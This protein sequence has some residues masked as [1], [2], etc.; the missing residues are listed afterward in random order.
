MGPLPGG[1][2]SR[3]GGGEGC[4]KAVRQTFVRALKCRPKRG[5]L[6]YPCRS[7]PLYSCRI[8]TSPGQRSVH[9]LPL[10]APAN[11]RAQ[12]LR[13]VK[14]CTG[15]SV[16]YDGHS[17][18]NDA[19]L[20]REAGADCPSEVWQAPPPISHLGHR[21]WL[22]RTAVARKRRCMH[23]PT[24]ASP[25]SPFQLV[26][27]CLRWAVASHACACARRCQ[28]AHYWWHAC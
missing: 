2:V 16:H 25:R 26:F 28:P 11:A 13:W 27:H 21:R 1:R 19:R 24:H 5:Q 3:G 15:T 18:S 10:E 6:R 23:R 4:R 14:S 7:R 12:G 8:S 17:T 22:L 20:N 9:Q